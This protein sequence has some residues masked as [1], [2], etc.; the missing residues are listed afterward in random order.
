MKAERSR[1]GRCGRE[2]V[3]H[4]IYSGE[5][6]CRSCFR[7]S[8]VDKTR[9]T[10]SQYRMLK[11]GDTVAV[12]V[13]GGKDSLSLVDVLSRLSPDHGERL[14]AITVDEG[15]G[16]YRE[17]AVELARRAVSDLGLQ[18]EVV[19][20]RELFG[21][22]LDEALAA[23]ADR[24]VS[25]CAVCGV[26]RR[27]AIDLA[28]EQ[29]A[30]TVV[31]TAHNLDDFLQTY[32]INLMSGDT[33]RMGFLDPGFEPRIGLPRRVKPF[34]KIL[35]EEIAFYAYLSGIPFQTEP[36]PYMDEGIRTE[37][38][39]FLNGL[40][41]RHPGIK[42]TTF[43]TALKVLSED[44]EARRSTRCKECGRPSSD[45]VC[46]VCRTLQAIQRGIG[47][48]TARIDSI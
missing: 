32:L 36:C 17:E 42:H 29:V 20:F 14:V 21:F 47:S 15:I 26:L 38:R 33:R 10:I 35:E 8:V 19:A 25:A 40:E 2:Q 12:A 11:H 24:N 28:A 16:G 41:R 48:Q 1:C 18:H 3:Y 45:E 27:R 7:D 9:R 39:D 31:V 46:T 37:I 22:T 34:L 6:L 30:A 4:R 5:R 23:I 44:Q 13:S 43:K